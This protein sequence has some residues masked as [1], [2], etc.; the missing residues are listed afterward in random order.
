CIG[1]PADAPSTLAVG[2]VD[3]N[4]ELAEFS[5][6]GP[7][8]RDVGLK[9]DITAPGVQISAAQAAGTGETDA[10]YVGMSGTSMAA[11]HVAGAAAIIAQAYPALDGE[12][13]KALLMSTARP[14]DGL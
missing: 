4:D 2:A 6:R 12:G 14:T 9:P 13:L 5:S 10:P 1:S 11:P 8:Y 3:R 7:V